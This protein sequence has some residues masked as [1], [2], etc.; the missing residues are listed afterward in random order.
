MFLDTRL[1]GA[2]G[3]SDTVLL[4]GS[5]GADT[6]YVAKDFSSFFGPSYRYTF[7]GIPNF[8][9]APGPDLGGRD[10]LIFTD[11][12]GDDRFDA[13][14]D[15]VRINGPD[16]SYQV[17]FFDVIRAH[18]GRG[19]NDTATQSSPNGTVRLSGNWK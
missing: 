12:E 10:R 1:D 4:S 7:S 3:K 17:K 13:A 14:G 9:T 16:Y 11:S 19:G 8:E 2:V 6:L 5:A 15:T 18:S